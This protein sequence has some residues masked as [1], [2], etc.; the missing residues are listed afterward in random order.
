M[1]LESIFHSSEWAVKALL[2]IRFPLFQLQIH[3]AA[4]VNSF[5][6]ENPVWKIC[7]F[8]LFIRYA[9]S[10]LCKGTNIYI[11]VLPFFLYLLITIYYY[12]L[13]FSILAPLFCSKAFF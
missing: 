6:P 8:V 1:G 7:I 2:Q 12:L 10:S 11:I 4:S 5:D 13:G 9:S 3:V